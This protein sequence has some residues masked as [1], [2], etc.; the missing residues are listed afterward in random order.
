VNNTQG[1][2]T[3]ELRA[4]T[5][6]KSPSG[7]EVGAVGAGA[8][9]LLDEPTAACDAVTCAAVEAAI[10][11]SGL[12]VIMITHDERQAQR[13]AHSRLIMTV[14]TDNNNTSTMAY[15]Q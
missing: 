1:D 2:D 5:G 7:S 8:V 6:S 9:L 11:S 13:L 4:E 10:V 12:T 3:V 15:S 14:A